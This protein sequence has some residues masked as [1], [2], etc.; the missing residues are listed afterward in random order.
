LNSHRSYCIF[1]FPPQNSHQFLTF[2][3]TQQSHRHLQ[4]PTVTPCTYPTFMHYYM[5]DRNK[6]CK[7]S[8]GRGEGTEKGTEEGPAD[9]QHPKTLG[10]L[11]C[12]VGLGHAEAPLPYLFL[13]KGVVW[14]PFIHAPCLSSFLAVF[15]SLVLVLRCLGNCCSTPRPQPCALQMYS[16]CHSP[17]SESFV[18]LAPRS[19]QSS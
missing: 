15:A 10:P 11:P 13:S 18:L 3:K 7:G 9:A 16:T 6:P 5:S 2:S 8:S 17:Y 19:I 14:L 4:A 12:L 1:H